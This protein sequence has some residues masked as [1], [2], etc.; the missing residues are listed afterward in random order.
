MKK[1]SVIAAVFGLVVFL[2]ANVNAQQSH[3]VQINIQQLADLDF[4]L[5]NNQEVFDFT[6]PE[7]LSDGIGRYVGDYQVKSNRNWRIKVKAQGLQNV[8]G[9][10]PNNFFQVGLGENPENIS[11]FIS[12][13]NSDQDL[14]Q[15]N[16]GAGQPNS[17]KISYK[18]NPGFEVEPQSYNLQVVYTLSQD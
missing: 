14:V 7:Q 5:Q 6:T 1:V 12:L 17:G 16:K 13:T 15:G 10:V 8:Q 9:N 18:V 4:S 11:N 3:D 2:S